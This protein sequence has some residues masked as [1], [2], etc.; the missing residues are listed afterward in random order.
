M[1]VK[2]VKLDPKHRIENFGVDQVFPHRTS[3]KDASKGH[4]TRLVGNLI[5]Y[6]YLIEHWL[7]P[8]KCYLCKLF[9]GHKEQ[10]KILDSLF[11]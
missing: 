8:R 5:L 9:V 1:Y 6:L 11:Y 10:C 2:F 7:N 4:L 3:I